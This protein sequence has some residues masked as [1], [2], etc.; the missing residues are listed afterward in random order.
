MSTFFNNTVYLDDN[1]L[2]FSCYFTDLANVYI[3]TEFS[4]TKDSQTLL[5]PVPI[6]SKSFA[7]QKGSL[8][9][10]DQTNLFISLPQYPVAGRMIIIKENGNVAH[11]I[12]TLDG[13]A[14]D[15]NQNPIVLAAGGAVKLFYDG[16]NWSSL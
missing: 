10:A 4:F 3:N 15:Q 9:L 7:I 8:F 16:S 11:T 1:F 2:P 13:T 6:D 12:A 14:I 5:E